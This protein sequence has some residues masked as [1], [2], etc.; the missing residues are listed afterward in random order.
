[1]KSI[2]K[3][4]LLLLLVFGPAI[5]ISQTGDTNQVDSQGRKQGYWKKFSK[6]TLK[7]VGTFKDDYPEGEFKYFYPDKIVKSIVQYS[8]KGLMAKVVSYYESGKKLAEGEYWDKKKHGL[9][10]MYNSEGTLT[11]VE[12]Y[13]YG[14]PEGEWITYYWEG[15]PA[16]IKHYTNGKLNGVFL[17]FAPD[18]IVNIKGNYTDNKINGQIY[19]YYPNGVPMISG[20]MVNDSKEGIWMYFTEQSISDKRITYSHDNILKEEINVRGPDKKTTFIDMYNIAYVFKSEGKVTIRLNDGTDLVS[21]RTMDDFQYV[22]DE[23]KFFRLNANYIISLWSVTNR[24]TY[25]NS[26]RVVI[27]KPATTSTVYVA[28]EAAEGFLHWEG[29]IKGEVDPKNPPDN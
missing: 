24:T 14:V 25:S 10:K 6:D 8:E 17:K 7:Y 18:S 5:A 15:K 13:H 21:E 4:F 12:D 23:Y 29:L 26:Q 3:I 28:D 19:Y 20:S 22:L 1:M 16:E 27:L 11:A 9:W 2:L